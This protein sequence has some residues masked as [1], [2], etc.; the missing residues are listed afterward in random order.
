MRDSMPQRVVVIGG[1]V[2]GL[3][4]AYHLA[5][6]GA[7]VILLEKDRIGAGSSS[8]AAGIITGLLW[9]EPGVA[10]RKRSL[11]LFRQFS[12]E[13]DGYTFHA[14]GCLNL[15]DRASWPEREALL[16]L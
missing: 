8:R 7:R 1:G 15:F 16:P 14:P 4:T 6:R 9:D 11:A 5:I 13:W 12:E 2:V 3:S 10:A